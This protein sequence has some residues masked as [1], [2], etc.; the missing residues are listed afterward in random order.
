MRP[1]LSHG[2]VWGTLSFVQ[3]L[4]PCQVGGDETMDEKQELNL[5]CALGSKQILYNRA[6]TRCFL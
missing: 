6:K 4:C 1:M 2:L 5:S 3:C